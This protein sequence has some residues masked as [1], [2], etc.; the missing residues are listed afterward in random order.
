MLFWYGLCIAVGCMLAY[1]I[2]GLVYHA[3]FEKPRSVGLMIATMLVLVTLAACG[4]ALL[5]VIPAPPR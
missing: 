1:G 4:L 2:L 5:G 3:F